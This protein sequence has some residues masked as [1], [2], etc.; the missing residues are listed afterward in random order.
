MRGVRSQPGWGELRP[1]T[2]PAPA[3]QTVPEEVMIDAGQLEM[4]RRVSPD[5]SLLRKVVDAFVVEMPANLSALSD[6]VRQGDPPSVRQATHRM[7]GAAANLGATAVAGLC[8]QLEQLAL[9][10]HLTAAPVILVGLGAELER[11]GVA[12]RCA[13]ELPAS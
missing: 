2:A 1:A 5:G 9:E 13:S 6:A 11:A 4:L 3:S 12:L 7:R 8:A 10:G